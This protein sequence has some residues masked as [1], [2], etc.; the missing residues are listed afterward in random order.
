MNRDGRR[1]LPEP[2]NPPIGGVIDLRLPPGPGQADI[3][4]SPLLL[5]PGEA[6]VVQRPLVR[7][8]TLL[9][10][11]QK[12]DVEF[13]PLRRM[14]RHDRDPLA[15]LAAF[16]VHDQRHMFEKCPKI[17][18]FAHRPDEFFEIV[19][20]SG[21]IGRALGLPHVD[22]AALLE[23][24]LRQ[25]FMRNLARLLPPPIEVVEKVAQDLPRTRLSAPPFRPAR[26]RPA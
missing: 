20:T 25:L 24:E 18:K 13:Q 14:K 7:K 2:A 10:A 16:G 1:R 22:V 6:I 9:P 21:R 11:R 26:A 3:G 12:D 5:E 8:K 23:H 15:L 4:K 17:G 19:E